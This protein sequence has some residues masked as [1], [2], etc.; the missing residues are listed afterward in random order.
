MKRLFDIVMATAA[1]V[2]FFPVFLILMV[3]VR[4]KLGAPVFFVQQRSGLGG[5]LFPMIKFRTMTGERD[6]EGNLLS[7]SERLGSFG[8]WLRSSSLDELPEL[9]NVIRGDMSLVGPRPLL[10]EYLPLYSERQ[11]RRHDVLPGITG[12]A[13]VNGRNALSWDDRFELDVWYVENRSFWLDLKIMAMTV[14]AVCSRKGVAAEGE[15]TMPRFTGAKT[16][17]DA[18]TERGLLDSN[19]ELGEAC[20]G[21]EQ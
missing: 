4:A 18:E 1:A 20:A 19:G 9:W 3:M 6:A 12:W 10:A 2:L 17:D 11:K 21:D 16:V 14:V 15:S 5:R 13:Q 7:D 8:T